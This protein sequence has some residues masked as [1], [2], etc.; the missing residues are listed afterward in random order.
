MKI[1][2]C[3]HERYG[4]MKTAANVDYCSTRYPPANGNHCNSAPCSSRTLVFKCSMPDDTITKFSSEDFSD[5]IIDSLST[6]HIGEVLTISTFKHAYF[7]VPY[8]EVIESKDSLYHHCSQP[9]IKLIVSPKPNV[10]QPGTGDNS[11]SPFPL[12]RTPQANWPGLAW[13]LARSQSRMET[14]SL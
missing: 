13:D 3:I 10:M 5:I 1:E 2:L 11:L 8:L 14:A 12:S 7:Q 4:L 6:M 9:Y